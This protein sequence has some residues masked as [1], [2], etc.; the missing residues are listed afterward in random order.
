MTHKC[1][2]I[3]WWIVW[4]EVVNPSNNGVH[5]IN[6]F[7]IGRWHF[8]ATINQW[9]YITQTVAAHT[10]THTRWNIKKWHH[11]KLYHSS[12]IPSWRRATIPGLY[13]TSER[14]RERDEIHHWFTSCADGCLAVYCKPLSIFEEKIDGKKKQWYRQE[15]TLG[16]GQGWCSTCMTCMSETGP[17]MLHYLSNQ[18]PT[19][20]SLLFGTAI[21]TSLNNNLE[22]CFV[23]CTCM[24][25][26]DWSKFNIILQC[27]MEG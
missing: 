15:Y 17:S 2:L 13:T 21:P 7:V 27:H 22:L 5:F 14:E 19:L 3:R 26:W 4:V 1:C 16:I 12:E 23:L 18:Q 24:Y 25:E 8:R 10:H 9:T 6:C 11:F 20:V